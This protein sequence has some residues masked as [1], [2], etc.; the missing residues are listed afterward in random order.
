MRETRREWREG[1]GGWGSQWRTKGRGSRGTYGRKTFEGVGEWKTI[2]MAGMTR[3]GMGLNGME[4][5]SKA[6]M[7]GGEI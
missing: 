5:D 3:D 4:W 2:G 6:N 1:L 7:T